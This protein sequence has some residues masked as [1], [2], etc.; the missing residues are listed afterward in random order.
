MKPWPHNTTQL[1]Y[2][3]GSDTSKAAADSMESR[4]PTIRKEVYDFIVSRGE[5]GATDDEIAASLNLRHQTASPRRRNLVL[6]GAVHRTEERRPTRSG[7]S[8]TVWI[9]TPGMDVRRPR[10]RPPKAPTNTFSRKLTVYLT[11][12]QDSQLARVARDTNQTKGQVARR[13][14]GV[15]FA[16][17]MHGEWAIPDN[18]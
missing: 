16:V 9:A 7:H 14:I 13:L 12:E 11:D 4:A 5:R 18:Q 3:K 8:A 1:P 2:T 6:M 15:G 17:G 10:G